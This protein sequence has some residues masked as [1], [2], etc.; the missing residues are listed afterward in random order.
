MDFCDPMTLGTLFSIG[1]VA[2]A[3]VTRARFGAFDADET[4]PA[5]LAQL[6]RHYARRARYADAVRA[7]ERA[8]TLHER[9]GFVLRQIPALKNASS[10]LAKVP[11]SEEQ[12]RITLTKLAKVY[13]SIGRI[14]ET[15][16]VKAEIARLDAP[17]EVPLGR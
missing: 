9:D 6:A 12:Q 15:D 4:N 10:L 1:A 16:E 13:E 11:G 17:P 14:R 7:Y 3:L 5:K 2:L 8:A